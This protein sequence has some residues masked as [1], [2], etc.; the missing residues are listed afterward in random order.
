MNER[1][2]SGVNG[3]L[4]TISETL[5]GVADVLCQISIESTAGR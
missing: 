3:E 2:W 5:D 4:S 1:Q